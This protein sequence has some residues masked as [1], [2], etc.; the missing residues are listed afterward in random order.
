M[1]ISETCFEQQKEIVLYEGAGVKPS[2]RLAG[3]VGSQKKAGLQ[4]LDVFRII[5][6]LFMNEDTRMQE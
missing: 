2:V 5:C 4:K 6:I 3:F 1:L